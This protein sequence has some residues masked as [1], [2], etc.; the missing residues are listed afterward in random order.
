MVTI[1]DP[2]LVVLVG[3]SGAG[4]TTWAAE[5]YRAQEIVSSDGLRGIVGSGEHDLE[6]STDAF[7]VLDQ[8]VA[9]RTRRGLTTLV[10][11]L[12][13]CLL[14]NLTLPTN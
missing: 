8:I 6:A 1:P 11:T 4:K 2:C 10:D 14:Y 3:P 7:A 13:L 9:A 5:R 12:G